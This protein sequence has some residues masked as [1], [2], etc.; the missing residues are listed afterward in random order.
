MKMNK[1][2]FTH[3]SRGIAWLDTGN[4]NALHDA[5][6]FI[7]V[8]EERTGLKIACLEEIALTYGWVNKKSIQNEIKRVDNS[9]NT[10]LKKLIQ[11][12]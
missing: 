10:Y 8:I 9:Y 11:G 4:P 5:S 12:G 6:T 7:R 1:L 2:S 3:L